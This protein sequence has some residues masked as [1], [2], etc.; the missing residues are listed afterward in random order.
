[1]QLL[2]ALRPGG[3]R[4]RGAQG[5]AGPPGRLGHGC[6]KHHELDISINTVKSHTRT[7]YAKLGVNTRRAA[8]VAAHERGLLLIGPPSG[9]RVHHPPRVV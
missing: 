1:V 4:V 2:V 6:R 8:V 5:P 9:R 7:N 3:L